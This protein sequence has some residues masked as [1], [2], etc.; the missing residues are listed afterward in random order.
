MGSANWKVSLHPR[1]FDKVPGAIQKG[2]APLLKDYETKITAI[3]TEFNPPGYL[4]E[5]IRKQIKEMHEYTVQ[6]YYQT[7]KDSVHA[8][9]T[10]TILLRYVPL[11]IPDRHPT[12]EACNRYRSNASKIIEELRD[13]ARD[14]LTSESTR[15]LKAKS[16]SVAQELTYIDDLAGLLTKGSLTFNESTEKRKMIAKT[17]LNFG[18]VNEFMEGSLI[19]YNFERF[20]N[21]LDRERA[22]FLYATKLVLYPAADGNRI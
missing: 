9:H 12:L 20:V 6:R 22:H 17:L 8:R 4:V 15:Q 16:D 5:A 18:K 7:V 13:T 2:F 10:G 19:T 14:L 11:Y 1:S 21:F 3:V